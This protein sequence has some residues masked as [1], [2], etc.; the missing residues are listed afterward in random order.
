MDQEMEKDLISLLDEEGH[1]HQFEIVDAVELEDQE[2]LALVPVFDDPSDSLEDS[3]QLVIL[4]I[5]EEE[6]D[7]GE[8]FLEAIEDE[9]EYNRVAQLFMERLSDEFDFEDEDAPEDGE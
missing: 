8:Q 5:S 2:Y 7:S 9:D 1:E 3:G 6:D 4:R